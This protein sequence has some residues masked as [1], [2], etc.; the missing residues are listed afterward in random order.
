[1][2][3]PEVV[4][5][6][7]D[8]LGDFLA[9]LDEDVEGLKKAVGLET[10]EEVGDKDGGDT[11][12]ELKDD[13]KGDK[14]DKDDED[15]ETMAKAK[16]RS[17][18]KKK[19][20]DEDEDEDEDDDEDEDKTAADEEK[21][22]GKAEEIAVEGADPLLVAALNEIDDLRLQGRRRDTVLK[23]S[24]K[25]QAGMYQ[26]LKG[27]AAKFADELSD[28]VEP[29]GAFSLFDKSSR[30]SGGDERQAPNADE[31]LAKSLAGMAKGLIGPVEA[32]SIQNAAKTG[33]MDERHLATFE[34]LNIALGTGHPS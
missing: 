3:K 8:T 17:K 6:Q 14:D 10:E 25:V 9:G 32:I 11:S 22:F 20:D 21:S 12:Y 5:E 13:E 31:V 16:V 15:E 28:P 34:R 7:E 1:M 2:A 26:L 27:M 30:A 24:A 18:K 29:K 23:K 4:E 19:K 33:T